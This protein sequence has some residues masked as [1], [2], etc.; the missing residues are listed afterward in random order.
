M[1][2]ERILRCGVGDGPENTN[3]LAQ[4]DIRYEACEGCKVVLSSHVRVQEVVDGSIHD[5]KISS[6]SDEPALY[7]KANAWTIYGEM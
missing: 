3:R 6:A 7:G 1:W 4:Y 2:A 5:V